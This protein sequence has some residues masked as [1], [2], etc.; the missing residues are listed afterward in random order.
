M[1]GCLAFSDLEIWRKDPESP[2]SFFIGS[3]R[4]A[5][6]KRGILDL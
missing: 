1:S 5:L 4:P 3:I 2:V 6:A